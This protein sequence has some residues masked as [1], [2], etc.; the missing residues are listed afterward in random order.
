MQSTKHGGSVIRQVLSLARVIAVA[1]W[2]G[3]W[4]L[5]ALLIHLVSR[6]T[7]L[8]LTLARKVWA[9]P[10]LWMLGARLEVW[11]L[12]SLDLS[13]SYLFVG[14]HASQLDIPVLFAA[15]PVPLRFLAKEELRRVPIV[16]VFITAMGMVFID[17]DRADA[18]RSSID[19]LAELLASELN[20]MAFPEGT[21]SRD[22]EIQPF[23]TG[24]FVAA[25]KS[26]VPVVPVRIDGAAAILPAGTLA[27]Q[28][29]PVRVFVGKPIPS[30]GLTLSDRRQFAARVHSS[31]VGLGS[32]RAE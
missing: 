27:I 15:L 31:L 11:G 12:E 17:R 30:T 28:P 10:A 2:T 22:G 24:A 29:G 16:G 1:L 13:R 32:K 21:R 3:F 23:K 9:P 20:L 25:I 6:R 19:Q 7:G 26:G 8:P 18:A 4:T 5:L 14:N